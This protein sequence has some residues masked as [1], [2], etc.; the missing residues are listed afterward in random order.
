MQVSRD[1]RA[2]SRF[3]CQGDVHLRVGTVEFTGEMLDVSQNGFRAAHR[4]P[5]LRPGHEVHFQ[6]KFFV[7]TARVAW[8]ADIAGRTESGFQVLRG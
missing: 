5:D 6:H 7:G 1:H 3:V 4:C 2:E 8:T